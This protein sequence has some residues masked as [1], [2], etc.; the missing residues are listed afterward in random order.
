MDVVAKHPDEKVRNAI[1]L[2]E[3]RVAS[4]GAAPL[5]AP[6]GYFKWALGKGATVAGQLKPPKPKKVAQAVDDGPA[7]MER[8]YSARA[9]EAF[10]AFKESDMLEQVPVLERFKKENS[11]NV[12]KLD[13]VE[14]DA[15]A[16]SMF[17]LWY[18]NLL[19]GEPTVVDLAQYVDQ[20]ALD[21][22]S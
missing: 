4:K 1:A 10:R 17:S 13:N 9:L 15:T 18:A 7:L 3:K 20:L 12:V 21:S 5:D 16:R 14:K 19:W 11:N 2:V 22:K 8:F 6:A